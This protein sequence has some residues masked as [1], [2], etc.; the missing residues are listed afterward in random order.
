MF[1]AL[2]DKVQDFDKLQP[3]LAN[4]YTS[5]AEAIK[6]SNK[7]LVGSVKSGALNYIRD[8]KAFDTSLIPSEVTEYLET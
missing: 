3:G 1:K 4:A 2:S 8:I 5:A 7:N 6:K